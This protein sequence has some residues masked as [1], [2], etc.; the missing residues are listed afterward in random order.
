MAIVFAAIAVASM[1][2]TYLMITFV[3]LGALL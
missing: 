3:D 1:I 2:A